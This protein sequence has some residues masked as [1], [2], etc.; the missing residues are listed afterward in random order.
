MKLGILEEPADDSLLET[1]PNFSTSQLLSFRMHIPAALSGASLEA[2]RSLKHDPRALAVHILNRVD[3]E[4]AFA[5]PLLDSVF[6]RGSRRPKPT[7]GC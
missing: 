4:E 7:G 1:A 2:S 3:A 6:H 5:E